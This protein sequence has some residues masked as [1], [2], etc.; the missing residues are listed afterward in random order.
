[1]KIKIC[2]WRACKDNF[3]EYIIKRIKNDI[4]FYKL[5]NIIIEETP[6]MWLCHK[7]P[8][9]VIDNDKV[10]NYANPLKISDL[11][12]KKLRLKKNRKNNI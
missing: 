7:W 2:T 5:N 11:M 4:E 9:V 3:S 8:N 12:L 1:M 6:C 10:I